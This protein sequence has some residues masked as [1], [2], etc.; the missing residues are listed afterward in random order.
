MKNIYIGILAL[1][2]LFSSACIKEGG[3]KFKPELPAPVVSGFEKSYSAFTFRDNLKI[4]PDV[5]RA[6]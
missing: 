5:E 1:L 6:S 2:T 4:S 3:N